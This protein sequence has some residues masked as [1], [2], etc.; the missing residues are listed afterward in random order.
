M[1][2]FWS[3]QSTFDD[4]SCIVRPTLNTDVTAAVKNLVAANCKFSIKGGGHTPW[5]GAGSIDEGVMIDMIT[6]NATTVN[7]AGTVGE[8]FETRET[9]T[10]L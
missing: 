7:V 3:L 9:E 4:P 10:L 5:K 2:G 1:E 8:L 6:M